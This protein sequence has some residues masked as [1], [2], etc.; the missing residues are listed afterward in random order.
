MVIICREKS[1]DYTVTCLFFNEI[2]RAFKIRMIHII[3]FG[4]ELFF[5]KQLAGTPTTTILEKDARSGLFYFSKQTSKEGIQG[6]PGGSYSYEQQTPSTVW[7]ITHSLGYKPSVYVQDY[8]NCLLLH[9]F[10]LF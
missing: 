9:G 2:H 5:D 10:F 4:I 6:I 1:V 8:G 3:I 7:T